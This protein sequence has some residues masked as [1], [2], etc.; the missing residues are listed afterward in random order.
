M[1]KSDQFVLR[2]LEKVELEKFFNTHALKVIR[3]FINKS[4]FSQPEKLINQDKD[5]PIQI[6]KEH[7]EQWLVHAL[8]VK[9]VGSWSYPI[10]VFN[11]HENWGADIKML[12]AKVDRAGKL[13]TGDSGETSLAQKFREAWAGLDELFNEWKYQQVKDEWL[14]IYQRK[15]EEVISAHNLEHIYYFILI[16]GGNSFYFVG[17]EVQVD[18]I[19][20]TQADL[21]K[22]A[23]SKKVESIFI[24]GFIDSTLGNAK[25]YKAKK[26]LELRLKPLAWFEQGLCIV[27]PDSWYKNDEINLLGEVKEWKSLSDIAFQRFQKIFGHQ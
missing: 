22:T 5:L 27:I 8:W 25:I 19:G 12:S 10:D 9:W 11:P 4:L 26:R 14:W 15:L 6:P 2:P 16:R 17:M 3:Y 1:P 24:N 13:I 7:I 18:M 23:N 21:E 20:H